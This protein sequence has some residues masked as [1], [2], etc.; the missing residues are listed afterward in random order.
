VPK[1]RSSILDEAVRGI[2]ITKKSFPIAKQETTYLCIV[3]RQK[4]L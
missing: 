4:A 2:E 1:D 3:E